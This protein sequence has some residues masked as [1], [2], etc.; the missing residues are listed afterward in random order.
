MITLMITVRIIPPCIEKGNV[1]VSHIVYKDA[2][3]I[4]TIRKNLIISDVYVTAGAVGIII[5][6]WN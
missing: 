5:I 4:R 6:I 2:L 3:G 1:T